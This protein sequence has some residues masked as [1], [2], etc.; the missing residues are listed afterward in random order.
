MDGWIKHLCETN[1]NF[2]LVL[3]ELGK[4]KVQY[5]F[6]ICQ[7]ILY[8]KK[9]QKKKNAPHNHSNCC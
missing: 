7:Y 9:N 1:F 5:V 8:T 3:S 2:V 6:A 4:L